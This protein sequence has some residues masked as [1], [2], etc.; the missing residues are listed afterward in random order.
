MS[1]VVSGVTFDGPFSSAD[2]LADRSGVYLVVDRVN[3]QYH[4]IDCGEAAMVRSRV[5]SHDRSDCWRKSG[6]GTLAVAVHYTPGLQQFGRR[7]IEAKLRDE[8][9]FPC[10]VR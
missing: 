6:R 1:L 4:P 7:A 9:S 5:D 8:H 2:D 10:G 3:G